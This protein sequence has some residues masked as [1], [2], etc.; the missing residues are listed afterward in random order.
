MA[1][2]SSDSHTK[3]NCPFFSLY[4]QMRT[5][6]VSLGGG[7]ADPGAIYILCWILK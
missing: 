5:Q 6:N 2:V 1:C 4:N 7:G 3:K